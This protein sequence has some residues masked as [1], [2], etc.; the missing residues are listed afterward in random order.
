MA[1]A[2][3]F[4]PDGSYPLLHAIEDENGNLIAY[5]YDE[6]EEEDDEDEDSASEDGDANDDE[7][8]AVVPPPPPPPRVSPSRP[9]TLSEDS[10]VS[11]RTRGGGETTTS[12]LSQDSSGREWSMS[13]IDGLFCPICMEA[14][15]SGGD[16]QVW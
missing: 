1:M 12:S 8:E 16:H 9:A 5:D 4:P 13:E 7:P 14:W 3:R 10:E 6:E 11:P 2:G 15:T